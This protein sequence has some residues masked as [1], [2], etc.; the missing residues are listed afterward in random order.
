MKYPCEEFEEETAEK[1][2]EVVKKLYGIEIDIKIEKPKEELADVAF[3]CFLL[4]KKLKKDP[5]EIAKE[6]ANKIKGEWIVKVEAV[7]GYV[8]FFINTEKLAREI[9]QKIEKMKDDFGKL[10][11]K[12]LKVI[13]EHTSA[14]PN[15]PLHVGRARNPIIGDTI[16]RL[17]KFGGYDVV[18]QY[19]VDDLGKQVATLF[20][21]VKNLKVKDLKVKEK[22]K[23]AD[24]QYVVYY[25]KAFEM[26][27]KDE[28]V[29]K[30]IEEIMK[31]CERGDEKLLEEIRGVYK[32]V[33]D[34]ILQS[35][36]SLNISIDEFVEESKFVLDGSVEKVMKAL[37]SSQYVKKEGNALYLDLEAFGIHGRDKKFFLTRSDGTSL[38]ATRDIAYHIWKGE[39]ADI[40]INILGED[41]KLEA[42]C[43]EIALNILEKKTPEVIFYA[44]VSLPEGKM[45]TRRGRV[46]Y[47]DDLIEEAIERARKEVRKRDLE[48]EKIEYIAKHV[49]VGA[50][51]YNIIKVKPDKA[52]VF[53]WEDALNFEGESAPFIQYAHARCCS[54][55]RK[56][57]Y[58]RVKKIK[59][60]HESEIKLIKYLASFPEAIKKSIES[61]NPAILAEYAYKLASSFNAFYRD[62]RVIGS[63]KE[64]ERLA[65]VNATRQ[66][67]KN[68]LNILGIEALEEM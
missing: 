8:N 12:N 67:L 59:Y 23:K 40:L 61:K 5:A 39:H 38:Y 2:R 27:E 3:P 47:L 52:I 63:E 42:K 26:M 14:N 24:H 68:C 19:Y 9:L 35:L 51:R 1:L 37:S 31:R 44:F 16:A 33:L 64:K 13:V 15:G 29:K 58:E 20:W 4:A 36:E 49:G 28:R 7:H 30:E 10:P 34:G 65:L 56:V 6:I 53:K 50:I 11:K 62:C 45:S 60:E 32:K 55:L 18:T 57:K 48:K 43:V 22:S 66:V 54:I 21:G 25:Q 41:H 46:V 17:L